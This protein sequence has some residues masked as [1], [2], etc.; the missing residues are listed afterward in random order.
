MKG[1][2]NLM[3]FRYRIEVTCSGGFRAGDG[4]GEYKRVPGHQTVRVRVRARVRA[5]ARV[6]VRAKMLER[7]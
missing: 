2:A 1:L 5:K 6:R 4:R 7:L 3:N